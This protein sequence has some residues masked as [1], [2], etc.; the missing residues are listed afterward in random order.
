M[1]VGAGAEGRV[2]TKNNT[3]RQVPLSDAAL[4]ILDRLPRIKGKAGFPF[5]TTGE[6]PVSGWSG[7]RRTSTKPCSPSPGRKR[8]SRAKIRKTSLAPAWRLHDPCRT[9]A[10]G[11]ARLGIAVHVVEAILNHR[12]GAISFV[13]ASYSRYDYADEKRAALEAWA[14]YVTQLVTPDAAGNVGRLREVAQ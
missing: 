11:M 6:T 10:S 4:A 1:D 14:R 9:A 12:T 2:R 13:A 8:V 5:T 7:R 3:P